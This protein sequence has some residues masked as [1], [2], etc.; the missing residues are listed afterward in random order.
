MRQ[1]AGLF[2]M[3]IGL[4]LAGI[5]TMLVM[6]IARQAADSSKSVIKQ[7]AVVTAV[8][9]IPDQ[10]IIPADALVMKPFPADFVPGGAITSAEQVAGKLANGFI[11]RDQVLVV[12][13]VSTVRRST[14]LSDRIPVGKVVVWL[15][16]PE[17]MSAA[18]LLKPGD[19][20]DILLTL[21]IAPLN[22]MQP[23][24]SGIAQG[25]AGLVNASAPSP[26]LT[27]ES[28]GNSTQSSQGSMSTQTTLQN[29]EVYGIGTDELSKAALLNNVNGQ[30]APPGTD[31][32]QP[33]PNTAQRAASASRAVGFLV[34]HQ[35]AVIIKFIKDSGGVIDFVVRSSDEHQIVRTDAMTIDAIAE[36]FR[37]RVPQPVK[38]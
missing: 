4:I 26:Q 3:L 23:Q 19:H 37:F 5:A 34:D 15:Q 22:I 9:D 35:D 31:P 29:V 11:A 8:R 33:A 7:V 28:G 38:P 14:N 6:N 1:R 21:P 25:A 2:L 17:M 10:A 27:G 13:Q 24:V 18:G 32:S 36:R 30:L 20:I 16:M 12:N